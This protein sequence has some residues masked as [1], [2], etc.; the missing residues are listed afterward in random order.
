MNSSAKLQTSVSCLIFGLNGDISDIV[1]NLRDNLNNED[2]ESI[3]TQ[4]ERQ[5]SSINQELTKINYQNQQQVVNAAHTVSSCNKS[6]ILDRSQDTVNGL[7]IAGLTSSL[8]T[9]MARAT[10]GV[11][12]FVDSSTS[13]LTH[14]S[15]TTEAIF[16]FLSKNPSSVDNNRIS[17][18]NELASNNND[19]Y[20]FNTNQQPML[21]NHLNYPININY[22]ND[23]NKL[24]S[25]DHNFSFNNNTKSNDKQHQNNTTY[26]NIS[27]Q[28]QLS[29]NESGYGDHY[30]Q[31]LNFNK[32]N[33]DNHHMK[34]TSDIGLRVSSNN[35]SNIYN[36]KTKTTVI[37][38][39]TT[40][41]NSTS[42]RQY[43]NGKNLDKLFKGYSYMNPEALKWFNQQKDAISQKTLKKRKE[44]GYKTT[45]ETSNQAIK[46]QY[47]GKQNQKQHRQSQMSKKSSMSQIS[48]LSSECDTISN[49]ENQM[50]DQNCKPKVAVKAIPMETL[51]SIYNDEMMPADSIDLGNLNYPISYNDISRYEYSAKATRKS[52][53]AFTIGDGED[54][55]SAIY[56]A[57]LRN[58]QTQKL[59]LSNLNQ[60]MELFYDIPIENKLGSD[61]QKREMIDDPNIRELKAKQIEYARD[62]RPKL[63]SLVYNPNSQFYSRYHFEYPINSDED[64]IGAGGYS[65]WA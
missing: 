33:N 57:G 22:I 30:N 65:V 23:V 16:K 49:D 10:L 26:S 27:R 13:N 25:N 56:S 38:A 15:H 7:N 42:Q 34:F 52:R 14:H 37:S 63:G 32:R 6:V 44:L 50:I 54:L 40:S 55:S 39:P 58:Q 1:R 59:V 19:L 35:S 5:S 20:Q 24:T 9:P 53:V 47:H 43:Y 11:A 64:L 61:D 29:A 4:A 45:D 3:N 17:N 2:D 31:R 46:R 12:S 28:Q 8:S 48:T 18:I 36:H 21:Q 41:T 60:T 62:S 51:D